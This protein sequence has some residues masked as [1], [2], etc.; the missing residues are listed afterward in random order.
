[1]APVE[2]KDFYVNDTTYFQGKQVNVVSSSEEYVV[3]EDENGKQQKVRKDALRQSLFNFNQEE[4]LNERKKLIAAY[5]E[6]AEE[7]G[8]K[9]QEWSDKI[10][11]LLNKMLG[12]NKGSEE[13]QALNDEYWA[14]RFT[15]TAYGNK[16]YSNY[17]N[18]FLVAS[19]PIA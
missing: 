16:E 9:K 12:L 5:Q 18:A 11:D 7:A 1:M 3:I 10:K 8:E 2:S 19:D 15:R 13:Y 6:K 14:A 4:K 17:L